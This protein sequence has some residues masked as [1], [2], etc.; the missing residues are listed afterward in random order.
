MIPQKVVAV[1]FS[2]VEN[3]AKVVKA[4]AEMIAERFSVDSDI[5][6]EEIDFTLPDAR[7]KTYH[8]GPEELV[9]FGTPTYA[10]RV[11]NKI[12]PFVQELFSAENT[13]AV[14]A[15]TFGNRNFDSSLTE[16]TEELT[17]NGFKVFAAG[18]FACH[19]VFSDK[20]AVGRPDEE[21]MKEL[22]VFVEG[23]ADKLG[24]AADAQALTVPVIRDG[25]PVAPYYTPLK[26]DGEPAVFLKAKP[27]TDPALCVQCG[28]CAT[29]CPLA[30][31]DPADYTQTPGICIKCQA[32]IIHCP[33]G[34]RSFDDE[35]FLS[36]VA[37]LEEHFTR[38]ADN[39]AF[40]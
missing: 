34:A 10:G 11:P 26:A 39:E 21:D 28:A 3:T 8:F 15:V 19:H 37:Y 7:E 36:H 18:A 35:A 12:L 33:T 16:L 38:R 22:E 13:P 4:I 20:I 27:V 32:C 30:S 1:Y 14:A 23:V 29:R 31:I 2:P 17:K 24:K 40:F 6:V 9:V 5:P 25:A